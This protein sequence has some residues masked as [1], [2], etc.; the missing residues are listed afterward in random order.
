MMPFEF[1][2]PPGELVK[3]VRGD[4]RI[5]LFEYQISYTEI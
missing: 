4:K 2:P 3:K 1:S 5:R